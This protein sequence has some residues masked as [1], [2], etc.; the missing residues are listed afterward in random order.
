MSDIE[1][2]LI[3]KRQGLQSE[4]ARKWF[5]LLVQPSQYVGEV[6]SI[7][8]DAALVQIHDHHRQRVGGIPSLCFLVATR[9]SN[10]NTDINFELEDSSLILLRVMDAAPLPSHSESERIR[11]LSAQRVSGEV[12]QHWDGPDAMDAQTHNLLS[13]AGVRCRVIG[14]FFLAPNPHDPKTL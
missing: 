14:T 13:F 12:E 11:V 7:S 5:G 4:S 10:P 9:V 1:S 8:Y 3:A 2:G 6:Y